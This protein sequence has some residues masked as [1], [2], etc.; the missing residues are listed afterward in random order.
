MNKDPNASQKI[1]VRE[2]HFNIFR[3]LCRVIILSSVKIAIRTLK[4]NT[5]P[6]FRF[7]F[8]NAECKA[9]QSQI[10]FLYILFITFHFIIKLC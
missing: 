9:L 3:V 4:A 7:Y 8:L 1:S 5:I 6:N 10:M 2:I